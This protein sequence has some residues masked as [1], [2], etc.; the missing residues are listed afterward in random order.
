MKFQVCYAILLMAIAMIEAEIDVSTDNVFDNKDLGYIVKKESFGNQGRS[1]NDDNDDDDDDHDN[2]SDNKKFIEINEIDKLIENHFTIITSNLND[3]DN[4]TVRNTTL[5]TVKNTTPTTVKN[6]TQTTVEKTTPTTV[7]KT[8]PTT[9]EKTT[10]TTVVKTTPTT[11]EKTTPTTVVKTTPTTVE[12][13]TPTTVEN[14]TLSTGKNIESTS[15]EISVSTIA[16][17]EEYP[18]QV[19][20]EKGTCILS[21]MTISLTVTYNNTD[22]EATNKILNPLPS[23]I[24]T[25]G[26]CSEPYS[27]M[28]LTWPFE[29]PESTANINL[30]MAKMNNITFSLKKDD[31]D[32]KFSVFQILVSIRL[33]P[34]NFPDALEADIL[35]TTDSNLMLFKASAINGKYKCNI[36]I[37]VKT[38]SVEITLN[39]VELIAFNTDDNISSRY[40]ENCIENIYETVNAGNIVGIISV[41][42]IA[43]TAICFIGY[44]IWRR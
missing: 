35:Q 22:M 25:D 17:L 36:P 28:Q 39:D 34:F 2:L 18:Y 4:S 1:L 6:T 26:Y 33:D 20:G 16:S 8:T 41:L 14:T 9:V 5:S 13:T 19:H 23:Y 10:P 42:I 7:E 11:V 15:S 38:E 44:M 24:T 40:E 12:K 29:E 30:T 31:E 3:T 27:A 37:T 21:K 32:S 43:K